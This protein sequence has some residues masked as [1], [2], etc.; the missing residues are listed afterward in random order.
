MKTKIF[1]FVIIMLASMICVFSCKKG[2]KDEKDTTAP[3][4]TLTP[5]ISYNVN[6]DS[7]Y[8]EP[9]Y[10]AIDDQDGDITSKVVVTNYVN[11]H[12]TGYY[13]VKYNVSDK[14][15]NAAIGKVRTV[16]VMI[17]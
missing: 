8:I 11:V 17:F 1:F 5:P 4:I 2:D 7:A 6:L 14:V 12:D 10:S 16:H 13:Q 9:G 15:G 3:V